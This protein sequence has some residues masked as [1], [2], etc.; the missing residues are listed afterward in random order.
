MIGY[1][2][3]KSSVGLVGEERDHMKKLW[4]TPPS[5][6]GIPMCAQ[7]NTHHRSI[8]HIVKQQ[9][10]RHQKTQRAYV[11]V[12]QN[13]Q[14]FIW[15]WPSVCLSVSG[16]TLVSLGGS[17]L[18]SSRL[19]SLISVFMSSIKIEDN[20]VEQASGLKCF[21]FYKTWKVIGG[22][23]LEDELKLRKATT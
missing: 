19:S 5:D 20:V 15:L 17:I 10:R 16:A 7:P 2:K 23:A 6:H 12:Q 13:D 14:G 9:Q 21:A 11:A 3:S 1:I 22:F 18:R 8:F 4:S